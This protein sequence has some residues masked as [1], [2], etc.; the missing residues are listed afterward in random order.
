MAKNL[1][2]FVTTTVVEYVSREYDDM[3]AG[4]QM[5]HG[6]P[7]KIYFKFTKSKEK[8]IKQLESWI[9]QC[10]EALSSSPDNDESLY[11]DNSIVYSGCQMWWCAYHRKNYE[12]IISIE[13]HRIQC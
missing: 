4:V 2:E 11:M 1:K 3:W 10:K 9:I 7:D 12:V 6:D 13:A 5:W 8:M